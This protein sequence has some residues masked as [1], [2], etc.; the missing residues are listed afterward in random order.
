MRGGARRIAASRSRHAFGAEAC[1]TPGPPCPVPPRSRHRTRGGRAGG[2]LRV[3]RPGVRA[4]HAQRWVSPT[5]SDTNPGTEAAPYKTLQKALDVAAPGMTI[6]LMKGTYTQAV[7][8]KVEG[9]ATAR[10][11]DQGPADRP[12]RR[13]ALR[14]GW[15]CVQHRPQHSPSTASRSMARTRSLPRLR[16]RHLGVPGPGE[17]GLVAG[18]RGQQQADLRRARHKAAASSARRSRTC[19]SPS[20]VASACASATRPEQ[21]DR[22]LG[23]LVVRDEGL[24]NDADQYKY[25]NA[26]G[27]YVGTSPKSADAA[28]LPRTTPATTSW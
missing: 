9:T 14:D 1:R 18:A 23:D 26:E 22:Q 3:V 12:R 10:D 16:G 15:A 25:H 21:P 11:H 17:E 6:N 5:G 24:G 20:P 28:V 19:S 8:T 27:V 13:S 2:R 4:D 7:I